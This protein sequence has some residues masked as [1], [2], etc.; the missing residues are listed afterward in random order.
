MTA[1]M[2]RWACLA[3]CKAV[4]KCLG[5]LHRPFHRAN[6]DVE[7]RMGL[8][9]QAVHDFGVQS[10]KQLVSCYPDDVQLANFFEVHTSPVLSTQ[11][12]ESIF[13]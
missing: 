12:F 10:D 2:P 11:L 7:P 8:K 5:S 3:P 6:L 1:E 13:V 9:I 4:L